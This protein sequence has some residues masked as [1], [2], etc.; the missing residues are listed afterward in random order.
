MVI[1]STVRDR[2]ADTTAA[3]HKTAQKVSRLGTDSPA[4]VLTFQTTTEMKNVLGETFGTRKAQKAIRALTENA[5]TRDGG[6][7]LDAGELALM[8]SLKGTTADMATREQLQAAIDKA[9]PVPS[10]NYAAE[11]IAEVY[12]PEDVIGQEVMRAIPV[13]DWKKDVKAGKPI[14]L[15]SR[16]V[17]HRLSRVAAHPEAVRRLRVLRYLL[18]LI[19]FWQAARPGSGRDRG[20]H[21]LPSQKKWKTLLQPAPDVVLEDIR[22]K[23]SDNGIMRKFHVDLLMTHCC[24]FASIIDDFEVNTMDL[25]DDLKLE[26]KEMNQYF[27]EIGAQVKTQKVDKRQEFFGKLALP[28]AFPETRQ[29]RRR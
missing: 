1:R 7:D 28:L 4:S 2:Q 20:L 22:Q 27:K 11:D 21:K 15:P 29:R 16:F 8:N 12:V 25:R 10:G 17:A 9:K 23:F 24:V 19:G 13:L 26:Q 6:A 5:I 14:Q 3:A 18:W